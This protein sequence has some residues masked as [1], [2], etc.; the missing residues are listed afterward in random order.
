MQVTGRDA[1]FARSADRRIG[2]TWRL[3]R[4]YDGRIVKQLS[5]ARVGSIVFVF[6]LS[7]RDTNIVLA[8]TNGERPKAYRAATYTVVV[9][10]RRTSQSTT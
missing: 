2:L 10:T 4:R 5:E 7:R 8:L 3:A 9:T 1:S 6:R